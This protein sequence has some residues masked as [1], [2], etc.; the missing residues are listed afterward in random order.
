[1][2]AVTVM[3]ASAMSLVGISTGASAATAASSKTQVV[4]GI[5]STTPAL[6]KYWDEMA[7]QFNKDYP[8]LNL[9]IYWEPSSTNAF[10][11]I[12]TTQLRSG[13]GPQV[14]TSSP[15]P[16]FTGAYAKAGLLYNLTSALREVPL[17]H[18]PVDKVFRH[19][20][21]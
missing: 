11:G 20:K 12:V 18:L 3:V 13:S 21:R 8:S 1:M 16:G 19:R 4:I 14:I 10:R 9:S 2:S 6:T 15:G 7:S 17:E 5:G